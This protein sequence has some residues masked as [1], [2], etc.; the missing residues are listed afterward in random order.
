[1]LSCCAEFS[2]I[3]RGPVKEVQ[4]V[5][6]VIF[7]FRYVR[8]DAIDCHRCD[9]TTVENALPVMTNTCD[10]WEVLRIDVIDQS[11]WIS[12]RMNLDDLFMRWIEVIG[13]RD[14]IPRESDSHVF[15]IFERDRC[16]LHLKQGSLRE[17]RRSDEG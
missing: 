10:V 13:R 2:S 17:L 15:A 8:R 4:I 3:N 6:G 7:D 14:R 16:V 9:V 12:E 11:E 5:L 1:M